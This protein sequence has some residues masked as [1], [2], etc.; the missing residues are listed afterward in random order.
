MSLAAL[1]VASISGAAAMSDDAKSPLDFTVKNIDGQ[2]V[3]LSKYK[4]KV[5]LFVNVASYCGYTKQYKGLQELHTKYKDK[6]L[7]VLGFPANEFG[8]QEPG[9]DAE[10]K[11]FC[12]S[13]YAVDFPMFSKLAV[14]GAKQHPLYKC[15]TANAKPAGDVKWNFEKFLVGRDG[16]IVKRFR[17]KDDP[18]GKELT[19]AVEAELAKG[20]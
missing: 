18:V 10:I 9:T 20:K 6:D 11:A 3:K 15:L 2:D 5:V 17:S 19:A 1:A 7:V 8:A 13:K 4:G 12:T 14:K 16:A